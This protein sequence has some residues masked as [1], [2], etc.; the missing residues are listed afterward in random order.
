MKDYL[1]KNGIRIG[2]IVLAVALLIGLGNAARD[3]QIGAVQNVTGISAAEP[4][5]YDAS[6]PNRDR[7]DRAVSTTLQPAKRLWILSHLS[8]GTAGPAVKR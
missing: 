8:L 7:A 4:V 2:V 3:G 5:K 1:K 6:C